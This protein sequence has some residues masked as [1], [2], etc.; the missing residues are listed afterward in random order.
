MLPMLL[1]L[2][3]Y[4]DVMDWMVEHSTIF[5]YSIT[6]AIIKFKIIVIAVIVVTLL[7]FHLLSFLLLMEFIE[8]A[9]TVLVVVVALFAF[10]LA[11]L[12][13]GVVAK[14]WVVFLKA[15]SLKLEDSVKKFFFLVNLLELELHLLDSEGFLIRFTVVITIKVN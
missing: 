3:L 10:T 2:H 13:S 1:L 4:F 9:V 11:K 8:V 12:L 6:T 5:K 14:Y 15:F 7:Q